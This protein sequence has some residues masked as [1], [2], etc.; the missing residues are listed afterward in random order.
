[1]AVAFTGLVAAF[2]P[3][4]IDAQKAPKELVRASGVADPTRDLR[5]AHYDWFEPS[6]VFYA[7]REVAEVKSP[8][9]AA[10]FFAVPTPGYLFVPVKTWE[11]LEA[12]VTVPTRIIA[13]HHDFYRNCE[14]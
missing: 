12:K 7:G 5:L 2:A 3:S 1:G 8:E 10:G 9:L 4:A 14:I 13:R 11:T 6:V